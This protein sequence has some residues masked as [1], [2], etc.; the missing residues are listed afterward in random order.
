VTI[1]GSARLKMRDGQI[2]EIGWDGDNGYDYTSPGEAMVRDG[3]ISKAQHS[4]QGLK[5]YFEA[6]PLMADKYLWMNDRY[7][8]F[9]ATSGGPY[10]AIGAPV[11]TRASIAVDK[12]RIPAKNIYPRAMAAF[13][14][15][16]VP[17]D[18]AGNK[19]DYRGFMMDQDTGG[20]IRAAGRCDIYMGIGAEAEKIAG[21]ELAQGALYY[22][23]LKPEYIAQYT[24]PMPAPTKP[25]K[26]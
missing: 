12:S 14:T 24:P 3:V 10:G 25:A 15:V 11:T 22:I 13:L 8:F 26:H 17:T 5:A 18:A 20:A 6:N 21:H 9:K 7:V 19:V 16:P 2:L 1:Q 4:G 23:A